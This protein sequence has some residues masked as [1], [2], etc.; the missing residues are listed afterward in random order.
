MTQESYVVPRGRAVPAVSRDEYLKPLIFHEG[1]L[2]QRPTP[3]NALT[4]LLWLPFGVFLCFLRAVALCLVPSPMLLPALALLGCRIRIKGTPPPQ[5]TGVM[6][7]S[8]HR[9][10]F[11]PVFIKLVTRRKN[12]STVVYSLSGL[13][14][15]LS[16]MK[17]VRLSRNR[18]KDSSIID[19]LLQGG[20]LVICPEGT[21]CREPYLL[22]FSSLFA[23]LSDRIVP[24]ATRCGMSLFHGTTASGWKSLDPF[25]F[26][27][28][29]W[30]CYSG[31]FL[32]QLPIEM[33]CR[34]GGKSNHEVGNHVQK[35][36]A[37]CLGFQC[38]NLTRQHKYQVLAGNDGLVAKS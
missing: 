13:S 1:R 31:S 21:T 14:E 24:V 2:V 37:D 18:D 12:V 28:N 32:D 16:P 36:L 26:G 23:E 17:T 7:V 33:T 30:P 38:T 15:L 11:D 22:R 34:T 6:F 27:L 9:T 25:F 29:P 3:L 4:V 8:T 35:L 5:G 19:T 20:D 10:L